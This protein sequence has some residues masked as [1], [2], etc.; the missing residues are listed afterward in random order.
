MENMPGYVKCPFCG[1]VK[2]T[3]NKYVGHLEIHHEHEYNFF[4]KC[5]AC[6][7]VLHTAEGYRSHN[8]RH[9]KTK[10]FEPQQ[11]TAQD[12]N[13]DY[14]LHHIH[15]Q[16]EQ[17]NEAS[18]LSDDDY[19][20]VDLTVAQVQSQFKFHLASF[21]LHIKEKHLL[22]T[23]VQKTILQEAK[24]LVNYTSKSYQKLLK[25]TVA[26]GE[27][28]IN[29][30]DHPDFKTILNDNLFSEP[31]TQL[32]S[33]HKFNSFVRNH[34][35]F[36]EPQ[37]FYLDVNETDKPFH[38]ISVIDILRAV[39]SKKDVSKL[40][41]ENQHCYHQPGVLF[42]FCDGEAFGQNLFFDP[43]V[44]RLHFY[45]DEFEVCNPIGAHRGKYKLT[46]V[47]YTVGNLPARYRNKENSIFLCLLVR[48]SFLSSNESYEHVFSPLISDLH[49]LKD[50]I[51]IL[52]EG[53]DVPVKYK[54]GIATISGDNLSSHTIGGFQTHFN[55]GRFCRFC[56]LDY[57]DFRNELSASKLILRCDHVYN[58]QLE[59]VLTD[60]DNSKLYGV[61]K[62]CVFNQL[63]YF[64][65]PNSFPPDI[66]H[67]CLEGVIPLTMWHVL[68]T[69]LGEGYINLDDMNS[70][71]E[72]ISVPHD[73]P[74]HFSA[75]VF[76][77]GG[78]IVGSAAQ[79]WQL[80]LMI[81]ELLHSI[82]VDIEG[83]EVWDVYL[84]L[85]EA[86][87]YIF[88][89]VIEESMIPYIQ[90]IIESYLHLYVKCFGKEAVTPKHHYVLH[91]SALIEKFGPLRNLWCMRYEAKHQYF[92]KLMSN[93]RNFKNVSATL[94]SRH[95]LKLAYELASRD[96]L[97]QDTQTLSICR[98]VSPEILPAGLRV[99]LQDKLDKNIDDVAIQSVSS[100]VVEG[101]SYSVSNSVCYVLHMFEEEDIP[102]F[103]Q[104]KYILNVDYKWLLCGKVYFA[105]KFMPLIHAFSV[106][107]DTS[108]Y[109]INPTDLTDS[110]K[111]RMYIKD[112][113]IY[114]YTTFQVTKHHAYYH[115]H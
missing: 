112:E 76:K 30:D 101:L 5:H 111:H 59:A 57:K 32:N 43:S 97:G 110:H 55:S 40:V 26:E 54:A 25:Q 102:C 66:M 70:F 44:I 106:S 49:K 39:L 77:A 33:D 79:K 36:V 61:K 52:I 68:K 12:I 84:R 20:D 15:Q 72:N 17:I 31:I 65:V 71:L 13:Q 78:K 21:M 87:D 22:P 114:M 92:K 99:L 27:N 51:D 4:V 89:P 18:D 45:I 38:Y 1:V 50:G 19:H 35:P 37:S 80:F 2:F 56:T 53:S 64:S 95:Q 93:V 82:I 86:M 28:P 109:A 47:Y 60:P 11:N 100:I 98:E 10:H 6:P 63:D 42:D 9:H 90:E 115:K 113:N 75:S 46:A 48:H 34:M 85:R 8:Y 83:L 14:D 94:T 103:F 7:Q 16:E 62:P 58:Y 96:Y 67:D 73:K 108:W 107:D 69:L 29:L 105:Q 74:N 104:L 3:F 81:P 24:F 88:S 91:Y 23:S 41:E